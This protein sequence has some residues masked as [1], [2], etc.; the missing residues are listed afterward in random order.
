MAEVV[1]IELDPLMVYLQ[2][3]NPW[4]S[5]LFDDGKIRL[6]VTEVGDTDVTTEVLVGGRVAMAAPGM[7]LLRDRTV[8]QMFLGS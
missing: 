1:T 4:S 3:A 7:Q 2:R 5:D 6:R 8:A